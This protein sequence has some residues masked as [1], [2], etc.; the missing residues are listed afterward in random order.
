MRSF[1]R[2]FETHCCETHRTVG[3]LDPRNLETA[4]ATAE[5][6]KDCDIDL[7]DAVKFD[8]FNK[9]KGTEGRQEPP[10]QCTLID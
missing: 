3:P 4:P 7:K 5:G 1:L 6:A 9:Y 10:Y 8:D 2:A